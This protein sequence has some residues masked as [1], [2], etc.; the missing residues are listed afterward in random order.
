M[1]E[2]R[3]GGRSEVVSIAVKSW[4]PFGD[5]NAIQHDAHPVGDSITQVSVS[6]LNNV[7][8]KQLRPNST[9]CMLG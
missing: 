2:G 4:S 6:S 3:P 5:T 1:N 7:I 8:E 9:R